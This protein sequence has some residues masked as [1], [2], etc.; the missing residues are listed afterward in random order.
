M[1]CKIP[2]SWIMHWSRSSISLKKK[3]K[4]KEAFS[5]FSSLLLILLRENLI[6]EVKLF[7]IMMPQD[8]VIGISDWLKK[9]HVKL[10]KEKVCPFFFSGYSDPNL[11]GS[12]SKMKFTRFFFFDR[13]TKSRPNATFAMRF[14]LAW[15]HLN[16][17]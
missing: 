17:H 10:I 4:T 11:D 14:Y 3:T 5:Y 2:S 6:S 9:T 1:L 8:W 15:M 16:A 13:S 7:M 12:L